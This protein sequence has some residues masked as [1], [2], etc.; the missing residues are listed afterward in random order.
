M[1]SAAITLVISPVGAATSL[2]RQVTR[3]QPIQ[4]LAILKRK[5]LS[6]R[7]SIRRMPLVLVRTRSVPAGTPGNTAD[8][9]FETFKPLK[10]S[11]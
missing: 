5:L 10:L 11:S 1:R 4:T 6:G 9:E 3:A 8:G 2:V 7:L